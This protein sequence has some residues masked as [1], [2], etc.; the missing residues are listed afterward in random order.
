MIP[1]IVFE[2]LKY[3]FLV[4]LYVFLILVVRAIYRD[5]RAPERAPERK[6]WRRKAARERPHLSVIAG[7]R[8]LGA[9]YN[10]SEHVVIGRAPGSNIML[11]DTYASQQ[12]TR[13][14][15]DN[16]SFYVEDLGSTNGTYVNGR[17]ISYPLELRSGDR[18]KIGKTVFEFRE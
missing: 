18:I 14:Y 13:I 4:L 11:E 1:N 12:H 3:F 15:G 10:L 5:V 8:N 9:R 17:K 2:V 16:G 7:E 6:R